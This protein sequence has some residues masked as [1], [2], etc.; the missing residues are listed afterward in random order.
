MIKWCENWLTKIKVGVIITW[1][2]DNDMTKAS[3]DWV[4][5]SFHCPEPECDEHAK[6]SVSNIIACGV[7]YC[8][9]CDCDMEATHDFVEIE[10]CGLFWY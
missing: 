5:V 6:T 3:Q 8:S 4:F 9:E 7:P 1:T 10:W 2:G